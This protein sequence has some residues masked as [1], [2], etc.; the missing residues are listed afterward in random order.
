MSHWES[1][2][3]PG[4]NGVFREGAF[5]AQLVAITNH[6]CTNLRVSRRGLRPDASFKG[7]GVIAMGGQTRQ[8]GR[9]V[10]VEELTGATR[11]LLISNVLRAHQYGPPGIVRPVYHNIASK[12]VPRYIS[13]R[14]RHPMILKYYHYF[15]SPTTTNTQYFRISQAYHTRPHCRH[16]RVQISTSRE[17]FYHISLLISAYAVRICLPR[18]MYWSRNDPNRRRAQQL[19]IEFQR[20]AILM[21]TVYSN[22]SKA[23]GPPKS[24]LDC[25]P[26]GMKVDYLP[27]D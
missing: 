8:G 21:K 17:D 22:L 24:R 5:G 18:Y 27:V 20:Y 13:S 14:A 10:K 26:K 11:H 9:Q 19:G 25:W 2:L 15:I 4:T 16:I 3:R 23:W 6:H 12:T 7:C 1:K